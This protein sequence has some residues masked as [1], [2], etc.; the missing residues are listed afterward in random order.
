MDI[1]QVIIWGHKSP[2]HT[3][4]WI[5]YAFDRAFKYLE[6]NTL[7]VND[8]KLSLELIDNTLPSL[9]LTEGQVDKYI[10]LNNKNFYIIHNC[11]VD[12]YKNLDNVLS[13]QVYT[14]KVPLKEHIYQY[15]KCK[16]Y[17]LVR[18]KCWMPW[19]T[20]LLPNEIQHIIN[21][22]HIKDKKE[23]AI[24]VGSVW[25]GQYGNISEIYKYKKACLDKQILF[26]SIKGV[27]MSK[28]IE[29]IQKSKYAPTIVGEWQRNCGY[30]PCR[31]FKNISYGGYCIT[32]SI[33]VYNLFNG[34]ICFE[35]DPYKL[36]NK[37]FNYIKNLD[38]KQYYELINHVKDKHTYVNRI[39]FLF[40]VLSKIKKIKIE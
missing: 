5:H 8:S 1:K 22:V 20:D 2:G 24:F 18:K 32:N 40:F 23:N 31:A 12:K 33:E 39:K 29:L 14:N 6:Y 9:F 4:Y 36:L 37:S 16:Y 34:K 15:D 27:S 11:K 7:W 25:G 19:A 35:E 17:N 30:I 38:D 26:Q 3:H 10:P 21:T 28:N 13:I